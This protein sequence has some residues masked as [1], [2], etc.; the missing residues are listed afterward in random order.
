MELSDFLSLRGVMMMQRVL[1]S[2][3][4]YLSLVTPGLVLGAVM[5]YVVRNE[6]RLRITVYVALFVLLRDAMTP[7]GLWSLGTEGFFWI[8]LSENPGFL[9]A[10][11]LG[12]LGLVLVLV[13]FDRENRPSLIWIRERSIEGWW[14]GGLGA[15]IVVLPLALIYRST[16]QAARGGAVP[17]GILP[18]LL[19][20]A[21]FGNLL[22]EMLFRGYVLGELTLQMRP[23]RAGVLSGVVFAFC[24]IFLATTVTD[25]GSPLL[26]FTLWEGAIAGL[27]GARYGIGPATVTHGGAVFLLASGLF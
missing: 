16:P 6:H 15:A 5:L 18:A 9:V 12:S 19:I 26:L 21:L 20:F 27:V 2:L 17:T 22:E 13:R 1:D 4:P 23:I 8:R 10:F 11:G 25:V 7:L 3:I 14:V 24:H